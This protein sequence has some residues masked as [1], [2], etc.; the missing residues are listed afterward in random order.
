[1]IILKCPVQCWT[2]DGRHPKDRWQET[3]TLM[4]TMV[5]ESCTQSYCLNVGPNRIRSSHS[6]PAQPPILHPPVFA[7]PLD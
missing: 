3:V 6:P 5:V 4:V 1:M 7:W 2:L